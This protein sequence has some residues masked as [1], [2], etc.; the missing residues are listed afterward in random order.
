MLE[1]KLLGDG[2]QRRALAEAV[3]ALARKVD[4]RDAAA[5]AE[6]MLDALDRRRN[7]SGHYFDAELIPLTAFASQL[8]GSEHATEVA[9]LA[10]RM[11]RSMKNRP[12]S[13]QYQLAEVLGELAAKL[14][15]ADAAH[16]AGPAVDTL[17]TVLES[18]SRGN[19]TM[20]ASWEVAAALARTVQYLNRRDAGVASERG[21]NAVM[22]AFDTLP[23]YREVQS[24]I[25]ESR[26][27][28]AQ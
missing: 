25:G 22:I 2:P 20:P 14:P 4:G 1:S 24:R 3:A 5:G 28:G 17:A 27:K 16:A 18:S 7:A 26:R 10:D 13:S 9:R 19:S 8:N 21:V 12:L 15:P 11:S 23:L 6:R